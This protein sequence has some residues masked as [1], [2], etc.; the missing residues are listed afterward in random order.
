MLT[1]QDMKELMVS[2]VDRRVNV[3]KQK[4]KKERERNREREGTCVEA[5]DLEDLGGVLSS[6]SP[7][8]W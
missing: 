3:I 7:I 5:G 6:P 4:N 1:S 2:P 8:A